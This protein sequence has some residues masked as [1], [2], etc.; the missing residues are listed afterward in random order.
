[1]VERSKESTYDFYKYVKI[2]KE[3]NINLDQTTNKINLLYCGNYK[4]FDGLLIS[5]LSMTK[6][7]KSPIKVFVITMDLQNINS[8]YRPI[9]QSQIDYLE[10]MLKE[11][12]SESSILLFDISKIFLEETENSPNLKKNKIIK[13]NE[14]MDLKLNE[15]SL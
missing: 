2:Q 3:E 10:S 11:V 5:L 14:D 6:Y 13:N 15:T 1:M 4:V 8:E 7:T 12:N 9:S